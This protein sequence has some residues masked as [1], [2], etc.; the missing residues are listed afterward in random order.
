MNDEPGS[1]QRPWKAWKTWL[2]VCDS[3]LLDQG[4]LKI[5]TLV[6][7]KCHERGTGLIVKPHSHWLTVYHN[8][9]PMLRL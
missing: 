9:Q 4:F 3:T 6:V 5:I 7:C 1:V 2:W 8:H